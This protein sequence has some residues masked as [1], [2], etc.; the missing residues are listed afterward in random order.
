MNGS[1]ALF[2][3]PSRTLTALLLLSAFVLSACGTGVDD[4]DPDGKILDESEVAAIKKTAK[5]R[6]NLRQAFH[7]K[8]LEREGLIPTKPSGNIAVK[9][10]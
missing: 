3:R 1:V 5:N 8:R 2:S 9:A 7:E 6:S 4:S 10:R